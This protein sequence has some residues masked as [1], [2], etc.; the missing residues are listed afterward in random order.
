[1]DKGP[2]VAL[3]PAGIAGAVAMMAPKRRRVVQALQ[4]KCTPEVTS[5]RVAEAINRIAASRTVALARTP[6]RSSLMVA[7][8]AELA[9]L[10]KAALATSNFMSSFLLHVLGLCFTLSANNSCSKPALLNRCSRILM[11]E[12]VQVGDRP[13]SRSNRTR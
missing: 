10:A 1:M 5:A 6:V 9:T 13:S 3:D 8:A 4:A 12:C 7:V 11:V 2:L